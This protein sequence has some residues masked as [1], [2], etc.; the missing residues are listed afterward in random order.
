MEAYG[1][2]MTVEIIAASDCSE[3]VLAVVETVRAD[4]AEPLN[5]FSFSRKFGAVSAHEPG[6]L[7]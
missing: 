2:E 7:P 1:R 5:K 6:F 4:H 3:G